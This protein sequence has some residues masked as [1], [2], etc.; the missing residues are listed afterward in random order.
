MSAA[1]C[2]CAIIA[3]DQKKVLGIFTDGDFRRRAAQDDAVLTKL[4]QDVM[5]PNPIA[6]C[7]DALAVE[8]LKVVE[9]KHINSIIVVD[10]SGKLVGM[11][12]I[13]DLP[14][15]KLL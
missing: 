11:I 10:Q 12:D 9:D 2:G 14:G 13:Q 4:M 15:M 5:T 3:D 7:A 8:A 1:R 6:V